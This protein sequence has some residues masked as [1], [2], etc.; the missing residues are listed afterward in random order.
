VSNRAWGIRPTQSMSTCRAMALLVVAA[1]LGG[2]SDGG[3]PD[4]GLVSDDSGFVSDPVRQSLP[5]TSRVSYSLDGTA[6]TDLAY[7]SLPP[8]TVPDGVTAEVRDQGGTGAVTTAIIDGGFDPVAIAASPGDLVQIDVHTSA[9]DLLS[10]TR[11]VP[12]RRHPSVVRTEPPAGKRDQA[13]NGRIVIVFSEPIASG[14][15]TSSSV[16]LL[17]GAT[18][19][20]GAIELLAGTTTDV[21][22]I[23]GT[24]LDPNTDY[25]LLVTKA[26]QD[27]EGDALAADLAVPFSTGATFVQSA[28]RVTVFPDTAEA[29]V[30]SQ[31]QLTA[32]ARDT[33]GQLVVGR[34][35]TWTTDNPTAVIVSPAG[36]VTAR[37]EGVAHV[38]ATLDGVGGEATILVSPVLVPV[39]SIA[40]VP[41]SATALPKG[42]VQLTATLRDAAG[43]ILR[44]RATT[45]QT[46]DAAVATVS[47]G[48]GGT[49]VV[50]GIAA[51]KATIRA[52]SEGRSATATITVGTVGPYTRVSTAA[53]HT[54]ALATD[55]SGWCWGRV[56]A[57]GT[58]GELGNGTLLGTLVPGAVAGGLKFSRVSATC[59]L[60][61]SGSAYCWGSNYLGVLGSGGSTTY[62]TAVEPAPVAVADGRQYS[63]ISVT[64]DHACA[65]TIGGAA[66]CWG[67]NHF[68]EL[69]VGTATGPEVCPSYSEPCSTTPV[70]VFGGHTFSALAAG[71]NHTCAVTGTGAAY[72]WGR[73]DAGM[74]GDA[75]L[76]D[77]YSPVPVAG[78]FLFT[79][80]AAGAAHTC[81]LT[82]DGTAYCWGDNDS[83]ELGI[84]T[85][86]GPRSPCP[87]ASDANRG[88]AN[89]STVPVPVSGSLRFS[90][91]SGGG[92]QTC[93]VTIAGAA[94]CWGNGQA[95]PTAIAG[96]LVFASLSASGDHAC[97]VT[98]DGI[99]YCWG[100]NYAGQLGDGTTTE[101]SVPVKVAGQR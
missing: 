12:E 36:L 88:V 98:W 64:G 21:V 80:L 57:F 22:F 52:T 33:S 60:A 28:T 78:G 23:P 7:V 19:I 90:S 83:A 39:A 2:C 73:N 61:T 95:T 81:G 67:W 82:S 16:Q 94:Y 71:D 10:F 35:F 31:V 101:S 77:R 58:S 75:T 56:S 44:F 48:L 84:G 27:L 14:T 15:L 53:G 11:A 18:R 46:S 3:G 8:G 72:C 51:G 24:S 25:R 9:G 43:N 17:R 100:S 68:G 55:A 93:A 47:E 86:S 32:V 65:L 42:L 20:A 59:A 40:V 97:G 30:G 96:G 99:A 79:A 54:C 5:G 49:A 89:C 13:L 69:G 87:S 92:T 26:V 34:P 63:T 41:G 1:W 45:W 85:T 6:G 91:I 37:A 70:A 62:P 29:A 76:V 4:L 50:Y 66:Y 38:Q 74:L